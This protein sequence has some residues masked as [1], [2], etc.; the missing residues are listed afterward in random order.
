MHRLVWLTLL[1]GGCVATQYSFTP[2]TKGEVA[3]P[4]GC[5]FEIFDA[6]PD[7]SFEEVGRLDH[8]NGDVPK[9]TD[10]LR[11][12]IKVRVCEV[13][14]DAVVADKDIKGEYRTATVIKYSKR[15][16]P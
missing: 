4:K 2:S 7:K 16:V 9:T 3:R 14:G 5:E 15:F 13:G 6:P 11:A 10:E 1:C 8:Y 12:A